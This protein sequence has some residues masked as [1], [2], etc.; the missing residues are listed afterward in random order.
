MSELGDYEELKTADKSQ[1][2]SGY[3]SYFLNEG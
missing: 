2:T 1:T 3:L